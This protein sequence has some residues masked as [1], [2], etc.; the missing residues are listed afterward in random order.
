LYKK[1]I[2]SFGN[3]KRPLDAVD[4]YPNNPALDSNCSAFASVFASG[5]I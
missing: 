4:R 3:L 5:L 2:A 1:L